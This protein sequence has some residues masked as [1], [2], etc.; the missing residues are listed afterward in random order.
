T[1]PTI[2]VLDQGIGL[3]SEE[4][5]DTILSLQRGNKLTKLHLIGAFGQGGAATLS[6]SDYALVASRHKQ[7]PQVIGFTLIRVLTLSDLFKEDA[8]AYLA[9]PGSSDGAGVLSVE[10]SGPITLYSPNDNVSHLPEFASGTLVRH[11][12]YKL[13]G[14]SG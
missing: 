12:G 14:I 4:F 7:N 9:L 10:A 2:D 5:P 3:R 1:A 8:Y 13:P 11:F 6:F